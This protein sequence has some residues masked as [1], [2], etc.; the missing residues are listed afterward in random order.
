MSNVENVTGSGVQGLAR[1]SKQ[2]TFS[3]ITDKISTGLEQVAGFIDE[4]V[5]GLKGE[6]ESSKLAAVGHRTVDALHSSASY[7]K[8]ADADQMKTDLRET[9]KRNPER[10]LLVGLG[11]GILLG[12]IFRKKG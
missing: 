2:S 11:V 7:I 12:A 10:S 8:T 3:K 1:T 6:Q 5:Q 9:I 4:K